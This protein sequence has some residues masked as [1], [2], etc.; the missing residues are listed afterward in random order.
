[1]K[2]KTNKRGL[3]KTNKRSLRKTNKVR[4]GT[5]TKSN[6]TEEEYAMLLEDIESERKIKK[7]MKER[8]EIYNK[9]IKT[10]AEEAAKKAKEAEEAAKKAEEAAKKAEEAAKKVEEA[11]KAAAKEAKQRNYESVR[12]KPQTVFGFTSSRKVAPQGSPHK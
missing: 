8:D 2:S 10:K 6:M 5:P 11:A 7:I 9:H 1:M 4:G 12:N 3:E